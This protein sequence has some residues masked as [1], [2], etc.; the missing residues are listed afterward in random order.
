M[1]VKRDGLKLGMKKE[2]TLCQ[3]LGVVPFLVVEFL[4]EFCSPEIDELIALT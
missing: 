2:L 4:L 1:C 3:L